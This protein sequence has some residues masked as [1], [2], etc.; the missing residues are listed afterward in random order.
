MTINHVRTQVEPLGHKYTIRIDRILDEPENWQEEVATIRL[1][2][3]GDVVHLLINTDGGNV[4]VLF[5]LL[6][7]LEQSPA[8]IIC[9]LEGMAASC[10]SFL[11]LSGDEFRVSPN[12]TL[13]AHNA[14]HGAYGK[15][16]DVS[17]Y[18]SYS[19][20]QFRNLLERY[21][22][23]FF[24]QEEIDKMLEGKEYWFDSD[25]IMERLEKRAELLN[26]EVEEVIN[27]DLTDLEIDD[28]K[29][30]CRQQGIKFAHNISK[31]KL[32]SKLENHFK[33]GE[34]FNDK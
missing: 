28:L 15:A 16:S 29:E 22:T 21:Y 26:K 20:K 18:V 3:E 32:I 33:V 17:T 30:T 24:T 27:L 25:E 9:E 13:M 23:H 19:D 11:F 34:S 4:Y 8:H 6:S 10:G 5:A 31:E 12:A 14:S 7:A 1:A 2:G